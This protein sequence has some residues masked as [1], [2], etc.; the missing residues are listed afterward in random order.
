MRRCANRDELGF[1]LCG[2]GCG[3]RAFGGGGGCGDDGSRLGGSRGLVELLAVGD[4]RAI[5]ATHAGIVRGARVSAPGDR[6][7]RERVVSRGEGEDQ[8]GGGGERDAGRARS[9]GVLLSN[10]RRRR[11][12]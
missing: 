9:G 4:R 12:R 2:P 11:G 5:L 8:R 10:R 6:D 1:G 3:A 7:E